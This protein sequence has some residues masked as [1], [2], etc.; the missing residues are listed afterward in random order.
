MRR[1]YLTQMMLVLALSALSSMAVYAA[2]WGKVT[3]KWY[4]YL[5]DASSQ[6]IQIIHNS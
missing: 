3:N 4:Y 6:K 5:D 2:E 1:K